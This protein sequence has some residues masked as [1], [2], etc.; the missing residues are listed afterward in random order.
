MSLW[1]DLLRGGWACGGCAGWKAGLLGALRDSLPRDCAG[2][3]HLLA[4]APCQC[5]SLLSRGAP[6][7]L[8]GWLVGGAQIDTTYNGNIQAKQPDVLPV[9]DVR[10]DFRCGFNYEGGTAT[11]T[12]SGNGRLQEAR[13]SVSKMVVIFGRL[14]PVGLCR[15]RVAVSDLPYPMRVCIVCLAPDLLD[16]LGL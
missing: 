7:E 12:F 16:G 13:C 2:I 1:T 9:Y 6:P 10:T 11:S 15:K 14:L 8:S 5:A 3:A 4:P